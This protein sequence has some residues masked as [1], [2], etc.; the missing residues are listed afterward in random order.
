MKN[1]GQIK[2]Q[3]NKPI[4]LGPLPIRDRRNRTSALVVVAALGAAALPNSTLAAEA[5]VDID[6]YQKDMGQEVRDE[7]TG[8]EVRKD[9]D[10]A[11]SFPRVEGEIVIE[12]QNDNQYESNDT[13]NQYNNLYTTTEGDFNLFPAEALPA[14]FVNFHLTLEQTNPFSGGGNKYFE[15]QGLFIENLSLN[16]E[17]DWYS[18]IA[19]KFGPNFSIAYDDAPGIYGTDLAE[20][21][22]EIA[23]RIGFGGSV[24]YS[25]PT[26]GA[27]TLSASLYTTDKTFMSES[28]INNRGR[29]KVSQ[30]GPSNNHGLSSG[31]L[32]V[33]GDIGVLPGFRYQ[34]GGA[35]QDVVRVI[36]EETG[37]NI[38][39][40]ETADENRFVVATEYAIGVTDDIAITPLVE[41][42]H[43]WNAEGVKDES[44]NYL[45]AS[46]LFT[47]QNWNLAVATTQKWVGPPDAGTYN[48]NQ[49]QVS[50]GYL[51]DFGLSLDVGWKYLTEEGI[52]TRTIGG[53]ASYVI[54]F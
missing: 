48:D 35:H 49:W 3:I 18:G 43:F 45:T 31:T 12:I 9:I 25:N 1:C 21:D 24:T 42:V 39:S 29:T 17:G 33:N 46:T 10:E 37:E 47:Y 40:S 36:D 52:N 8:A 41:Y 38:P 20:D 14:L 50:A 15:Q 4:G 19:G 28:A 53:L 22:I 34:I 16:Y 44:R 51:F 32:V 5:D 26:Y 54:D 13:I 27:H 2:G 7:D 23:E 11:L 30:G 6:K